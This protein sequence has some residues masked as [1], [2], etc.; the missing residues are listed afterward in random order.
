MRLFEKG[1]VCCGDGLKHN[2]SELIKLS[3]A[4]KNTADRNPYTAANREGYRSL[5]PDG[6]PP[7]TV[8]SE[9]STEED[10]RKGRVAYNNP[11]LRYR[12][13]GTLLGW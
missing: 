2:L 7:R 10:Q 3:N 11:D 4:C 9:L 8:N 6:R 1:C 5:N 12:L 13:K